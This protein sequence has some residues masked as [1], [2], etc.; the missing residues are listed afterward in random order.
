MSL[1]RRQGLCEVS[2]RDPVFRLV[3]GGAGLR[4][5]I[6]VLSISSLAD[7]DLLELAGQ[8]VSGLTGLVLT[9]GRATRVISKCQTGKLSLITHL[10]I[11]VV[12]GSLGNLLCGGK[13]LLVELTTRMRRHTE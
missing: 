8:A 3:A 11:I 7:S 9:A 2:K 4:G 13:R 5:L 10:V 6:A 1:A 12:L